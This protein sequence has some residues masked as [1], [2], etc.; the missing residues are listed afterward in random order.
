MGRGNF[1]SAWL[2]INKAEGERYIAKKVMLQ[3]LK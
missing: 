2:V 1:G 3:G